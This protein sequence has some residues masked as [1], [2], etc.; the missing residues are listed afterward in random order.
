MAPSR[1]LMLFTAAIMSAACTVFEGQNGAW[2]DR[3]QG[4]AT[5]EEVR[6]HWG[7]PTAS[8]S[9]ENGESLW[10][11][12][13]REEQPGSRYSAP[14]MWC[15]QYVLTFDQQTILRRWTH[16]SYFHGGELMPKE[17]VPG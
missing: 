3:A 10:T 2:L 4:Q 5:Q 13:K 11:Y 8:R 6:G 7:E 17:C 1:L 14:G 9:L 16:A 15:E 12:E